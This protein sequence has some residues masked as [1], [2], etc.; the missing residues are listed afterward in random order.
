MKRNLRGFAAPG[1]LFLGCKRGFFQ[2][3]F[4]DVPHYAEPAD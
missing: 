4:N 3:G 1:S 2:S